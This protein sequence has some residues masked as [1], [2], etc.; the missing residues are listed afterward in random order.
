[1]NRSKQNETVLV[2]EDEP[3]IRGL[4]LEILEDLG[5]QAIDAQDSVSGLCVIRSDA[6]IDLLITDVGLPGDMNGRQMA[7]A[8]RQ[9]RPDLKVLFITGY[10]E[11]AMRADE[12]LAPGMDVL[13][14]PF[15]LETISR[16]IRSILAPE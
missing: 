15:A 2:V 4:L 3:A 10:A 13:S 6:R 12:Q 1:M 9:S 8:A 7:D 11:G 5:Y 16:R 14:K